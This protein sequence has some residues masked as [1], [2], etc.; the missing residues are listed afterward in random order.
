MRVDIG[1]QKPAGCR[2][3]I[4]INSVLADYT[5]YRQDSA[6]T[7]AVIICGARNV[8]MRKRGDFRPDYDMIGEESRKFINEDC[9]AALGAM[10]I[11]CPNNLQK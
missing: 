9:V 1:E 3:E 8:S 7:E 4:L 2:S 11:D 5:D 6:N 10:C